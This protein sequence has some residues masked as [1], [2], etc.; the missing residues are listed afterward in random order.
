MMTQIRTI[1]TAETDDF[2]AALTALRPVLRITALRYTRDSALAEDLVQ[3]TMVRA[4]R[5]QS[6]FIQGSQLRAWVSTIMANAFI[7]GYRRQRREREILSG[8]GLEDVARNLRSDAARIDAA[9]PEADISSNTLS[10]TM[11]L[12][13]SSIPDEF[14]KVVMLCDLFELSYKDA[15]TMLGCPQ[16]TIMSR[17]HR[18][19]RLLRE[20]LQDE[21]R[22]L[23]MAQA[24]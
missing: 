16:G 23:G 24:A 22:D 20:Q 18:A 19:R 13:L 4:L 15:A 2:A 10:D 12:A 6:R 1:R 8:P 3:D 9:G 21:A 7:N 5:F 11:L 17:L 14:R